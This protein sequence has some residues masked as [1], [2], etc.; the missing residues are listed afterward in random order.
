MKWLLHKI[1]SFFP[2]LA[3][4]FA[5][6]AFLKPAP[7][8]AIEIYINRLLGLIMFS[9]GATLS[10]V[11]FLR[12]FR[13]WKTVALG[14]GLQY[15]V[16]PLAALALAAGFGL[17][18]E[19]AVGLVIVGCCPGG[20]ASN[21]ICYLARADLALSVTLTLCSTLLAPLVTPAQVWLLAHQWMPVPVGALFSSIM[22]IIVVPV[23]AGVLVKKLAPSVVRLVAPALPAVAIAAIVA[24]ISCVVAMNRDNIQAMPLAVGLAVVLHNLAGFGFGFLGGRLAGRE[25][26]VTRTLSVEVGMQNS[27]LGAVLAVSYFSPLAALPAALFSLWQ[28]LAGAILAAWW[29]ARPAE[30]DS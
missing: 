20:T 27:G 22:M 6:T 4:V 8:L 12:A 26:T 23:T 30:P 3:L 9:M 10:P 16:M 29:R 15:T 13:R 25:K 17:E 1:E 2:V 7:F 21:V 14:V 18:K 24:I 19:T 11:D 5:L 28:N